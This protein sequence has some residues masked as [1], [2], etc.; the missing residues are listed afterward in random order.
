M[1][2]DAAAVLVIVALFAWYAAADALAY[3][4]ETIIERGS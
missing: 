2:S 3:V 1:L 4:F